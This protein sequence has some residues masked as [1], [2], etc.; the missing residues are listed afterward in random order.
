MS[1]IK[2]RKQIRFEPVAFKESTS[3]LR[4]PSC[5]WYQIYP[6]AIEETP[7]FEELYWC[8]CEEETIVLA[9]IDIGAFR[10]TVIS[11][12]A[13]HNL[14]KILRFFGEHEKE[15]ILRIA[16]DREGRGMEREPEFLN[17]VIGHMQQLGTVIHAFREQILVVQGLLVGS[18]GEMHDSKFLSEKRLKQLMHAWQEA[19]GDILIVIRTPQ[20]WRLL[21]P[22]GIEEGNDKIGLFNDGLFG[23]A[24]DLGTFGWQKKEEAGWEGQWCREEELE[25][26]GRIAACIPYGGEAVGEMLEMTFEEMVDE[27]RRTNVCYLNKK[28]DMARLDQW[29]AAFW[30]EDGVW[31]K[32]NV[33]DYIGCHLGYR[34]V[35]REAELIGKNELQ[36]RI[37]IENTGFSTLKQE[38]ELV[39]CIENETKNAAYHVLPDDLCGVKPQE[40]KE[41]VTVLPQD[42][43]GASCLLSLKMQRKRD[44]C[45]I[46]FANEK[47]ENG[48]VWLGRLFIR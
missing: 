2:K 4:N 27:L 18:W 17:T 13:L 44:G 37:L 28:H 22:K 35:L 6:F 38:A 8:L 41:I 14:S 29:K 39:L 5:G 12:D 48:S 19:L 33:F 31:D 26:T 21:H 32:V 30:Q 20:Q 34:F 9:L 7:D 46:F 25:F 42:V 11:E 40:I 24:D 23:S 45:P 10:D 16:Y 3:Y 15:I 1:F 36:L 43:A 47:T